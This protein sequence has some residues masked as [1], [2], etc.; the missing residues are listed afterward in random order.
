[1]W[2]ITE[3]APAPFLAE[4]S[5]ENATVVATEL[6]NRMSTVEQQVLSQYTATAAYVTLAQQNTDTVRAEARA[7]LDRVQRTVIDL[8][9]QVRADVKN[10]LDCA[11]LR[12]ELPVVPM[13]TDASPRLAALEDR[14]TTMI[15]ALESC[16]RD[17]VTLRQQVDELMREQNRADGWLF[18]T[19]STT[20][21]SLH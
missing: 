6:R 13:S 3:Q 12:P 9:E 10:R 4:A 11:N 15:S 8:I 20:E 7:D 21:L 17:N 14:L 5:E 2:A 19:G 16:V 18:A 1:M